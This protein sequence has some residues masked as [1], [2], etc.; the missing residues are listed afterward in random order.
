MRILD[1]YILREY[2]KTLLIIIFSFSVLFLIVDISDR[3][4]NLLRKDA[5]IDAMM[6]YFLLRI[7]YLILLSSP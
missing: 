4:P 3:L 6:T 5:P 2:I 1:K 7:P